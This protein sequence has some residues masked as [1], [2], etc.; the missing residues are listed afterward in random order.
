[1]ARHRRVDWWREGSSPLGAV[2][3][4]T[5]ALGGAMDLHGFDLNLLVA[6]DALLAEKSVTN[7]GRRV[8]LSQS[9][10]SGV[11][12]RL[13]QALNDKLLVPSRGSMTLTPLAE[14]LIEPVRSIL[15]Q[16]H[17]TITVNVP[18]DPATSRRVFTIAA[19][20]YAVTVLLTDALRRISRDAPGVTVVIVPLREQT[21]ETADL[22]L[23]LVI[24]PKAYTPATSPHEVLFEDAFTAIVCSRHSTVGATLQPDQ[25]RRLPHAVVS[26]SDDTR[27]NYNER[28]GD[29]DSIELHVQVVVPSYHAL[30]ALIVGT[31]RIA[32]LQM[33][34]ADTLAASYP[35]RLVPIPLP[36]PVLE[37]AMM[38]HPRLDRDAGHAWLR[39]MLRETAAALPRL[40]REPR[41]PMHHRPRRPA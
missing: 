32:T 11:L 28:F 37:E 5:I 38:W 12:S 1:M 6:L 18:F 17:R 25:Y 7:A 2:S 39:G 10:M 22:G 33:R 27:I 14:S 15:E 30:P 13:R 3:S 19:S 20:D 35:I 8:H 29:Q 34:L 26:F 40:G 9:A 4:S 16:V 24:V 31:N 21:P 41:A 36:M 23:D